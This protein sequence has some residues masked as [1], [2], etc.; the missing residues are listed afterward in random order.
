VGPEIC[1]GVVAKKKIQTSAGN[2]ALIAQ[3]HSCYNNCQLST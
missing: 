3:S 2:R 1:M